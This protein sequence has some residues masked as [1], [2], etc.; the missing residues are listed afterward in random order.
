MRLL[1][2]WLSRS[3]LVPLFRLRLGFLVANPLTGYLCVVRTTGRRTGRIRSA[4][5]MYAIDGGEILL[6]AGWGP[7]TDWFRNAKADPEVGVLLP[8]GRLRGT[9]E[10][11]A[12]PPERA[13][14]LRQILRNSGL[15]AFTEG[16]DPWRDSDDAILAR[17]EGKPVVRIRPLGL[18]VVAG[19]FDPGGRGW[20]VAPAVVGAMITALAALVAVRGRSAARPGEHGPGARGGPTIDRRRFRG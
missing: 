11:V 9:A 19:A 14:A 20:L 17:S 5:V 3:I 10:E 12:A 13:R 2:R 15:T 8:G 16:V 18:P 7:D 6:M 1:F 4:A